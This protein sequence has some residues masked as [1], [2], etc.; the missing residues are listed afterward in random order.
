MSERLAIEGGTPVRTTLLPYGRHWIDDDDVAA[1]TAALRSDWL[2]TGPRV[3]EL[4]RAF[5]GITGT[6]H[7]VAVNSGTA[8]LHAAL[9]A[10][11]LGSG[12][13]VIVP[14]MTFAASANAALYVGATPVF[15]D[16]D[17][18]TLLLTVDE[19][20]RRRTPRTRAVVP[21]DFAG[22]PCAYPALGQW[23]RAH[24]I[25]ILADA[26][27]ALGGALDGR[28][29]GSLADATAF[30]LHPVKAIA[31]GE[32]G[33]ITTDDV[34]LAT[35]ART[36][37]NHGLSTDHRQREGQGTWLYDMVEL[38][39][40][41]RLPDTSCA[42]A[43]S[44]LSKLDAWIARRAAIAARYDEHFGSTGSAFRPLDPVPGGKHG[45]HLYV[46]RL[47]RQQWRVGRAEVFAAF[48]AEGIGVNVHY[49]PVHL[50]PFYR[51]RYGTGPGLC[52]NAEAAYE[53]ILSLPL[54]PRMTET[55][56]ADVLAAADK[57]SRAYAAS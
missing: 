16:V 33:V 6:Q 5:A 51:E 31:S 3:A 7:A 22:Q 47:P 4:E 25:R 55:D 43:L 18:G 17:P 8:A 28:P 57:I 11:R 21:V 46:V 44:Q 40:N 13:E 35:R 9:H 26:C 38:G 49:R 24:S 48:R 50:H 37:R 41:Y 20:D 15:A 27:H 39:F 23:A 2:T 52:P 54:F 34:D 53:E 32:G 10:M 19:A 45:H 12:D 14:T 36:F 29:V 42:L 1:V 30:S 56:V